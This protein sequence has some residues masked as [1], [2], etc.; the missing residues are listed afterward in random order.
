MKTLN[1]FPRFS[2]SRPLELGSQ[3]LLHQ[4]SGHHGHLDGAHDH[5]RHVE[6]GPH[7]VLHAAL[8]KIPALLSHTGQDHR[9]TDVGDLRHDLLLHQ[10]IQQG[11]V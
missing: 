6:G 9:A 5:V 4:Q 1:N 11:G 8:I 3:S 7:D 2:S 10:L